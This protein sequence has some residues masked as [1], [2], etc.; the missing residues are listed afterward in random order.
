MRKGSGKPT[1]TG[2]YKIQSKTTLDMYIGSSLNYDMRR[3]RHL[4][5]FRQGNHPNGNIRNHVALYGID[6]LFFEVIEE[7][8]DKEMLFNR[9][10][11]YLDTLRPTFN[12]HPNAASA[13]GMKHSE[14]TRKRKSEEVKASMTEEKRIYL[15]T[16]RKGIKR[17]EESIRKHKETSAKK[18]EAKVK[19]PKL[20]RKKRD[21]RKVVCLDTGQI[22]GSFAMAALSIGCAKQS[23]N[24][25]CR[26]IKPHIYGLKFSYLTTNNSK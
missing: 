8:T 24:N 18:R 6:D 21:S 23:V 5:H 1:V 12:L 2:V 10:Q 17:S 15:S 19:P 11:Y 4:H 3:W 7:V 13:L 25:V 22:F 14:Q 9:E 26:G 16:L 20:P